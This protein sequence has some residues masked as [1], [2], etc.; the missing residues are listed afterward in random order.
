[1]LPNAQAQSC[2]NGPRR[3]VYVAV[4]SREYN[5]D[6]ILMFIMSQLRT[7]SFFVIAL[8]E[9]LTLSKPL[10]LDISCGNILALS[11]GT[12]CPYSITKCAKMSVFLCENRKNSWAA[13]GYAPIPPWPPAAGGFTPKLPVVPPPP[14]QILGAPLILHYILAYYSCVD[15]TDMKDT[16]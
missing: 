2:G 4:Y 5:K 1:M 7:A 16:N 9:S 13:G 12:T 15:G 3:L 11:I 14:C 6:L 10:L 8:F